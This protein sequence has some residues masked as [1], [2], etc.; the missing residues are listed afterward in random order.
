MQP[1]P[2]V[3]VV[4]V[5]AGPGV[6]VVPVQ[7]GGAWSVPNAPQLVTVHALPPAGGQNVGAKHAQ[8]VAQVE[9]DFDQVRDDW[10]YAHWHEPEQG[11]AVVVVVVV[12][13][14]AVVVV[15]VVGAG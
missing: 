14:E 1:A 11:A 3:V 7:L 2:G 4:V 12:V 10:L 13:G 8:P 15:V 5:Q 6:V 9:D